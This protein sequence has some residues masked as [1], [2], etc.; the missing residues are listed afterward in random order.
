MIGY[1]DDETLKNSFSS[2]KFEINTCDDSTLSEDQKKR[3]VKC[4]TPQKIENW[5]LDKNILPITID[6]KANF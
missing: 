1:K 3:K 6:K 2:I 4:A 5:R